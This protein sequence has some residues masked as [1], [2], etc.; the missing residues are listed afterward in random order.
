MVV[1]PV[2]LTEPHPPQPSLVALVFIYLELREILR[3][4]QQG[5]TGKE[6]MGDKTPE[7]AQGVVVVKEEETPISAPK[8]QEA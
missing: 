6:W 2:T 3:P 1:A 4:L 5:L 7:Q 8:E